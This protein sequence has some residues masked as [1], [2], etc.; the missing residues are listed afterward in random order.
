MMRASTNTFRD[1]VKQELELLDEFTR[2][3]DRAG[4]EVG[5]GQH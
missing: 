3:A 1:A 4:A 2:R 5:A